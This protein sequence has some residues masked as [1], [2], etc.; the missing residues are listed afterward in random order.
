LADTTTGS[1]R[2]VP[3]QPS[4]AG[5]SPLLA[6][7]VRPT[8]AHWQFALVALAAVV[9]RVVVVLGYPP[10]FWFSDSYNYLYDAV[11]HTPDE[12]RS[13]GY[14][15]FLDL[16]LPLHSDYAIGLVQAAM[17]VAIGVAIYAVL[18]HR[19]LPWWGATLPTLPVLF[20]AYELHLEHMI[21]AD[22]L[23]IFLVTIAVVMLCWS[24]RPS[25]WT[26]AVA[27][28]LIGYATL[29]RSVGE[30]LLAVAVVGML[31]RRVGWRR[32]LTLAVTGIVPIGAYM[33]WF[34]GTYG[35][36]ALT[37]SQGGF[38]Y[39]RVSSFAQCSKMNVPALE[40]YLCDPTKL[41]DRP[42]AG[43]Y[44]WADHEMLPLSDDSHRDYYTPLY[45][46]YGSDTS[47]RFTPQ[48]NSQLQKFADS[49]I[50]SQPTAYL[51][52]VIDD[53]L[54]TFG[55]TRQPDPY[56][57][58]GNGPN[59][60]YVDTN[61]MNLQVPWYATPYQIPGNPKYEPG[62]TSQETWCDATCQNGTLQQPGDSQARVIQQAERDF[63]GGQLGFTKAVHPWSR[64]LQIY[65]RYVFLPGTVLGVIVLL[66]AV[67]VLA[68][69]RRWGGTGLL[70]WLVGALLIVLPPMTSGFSYRYVLAAAPIA[71]LAAGLAFTRQPGSR[72]VR[73]LAADLRRNLGRGGTVDQ[74]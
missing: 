43:E 74:E 33:I 62:S 68:R 29:V 39:S 48:V 73:A 17:G 66:G 71:C 72:S 13:N 63:D 59:F 23:F 32:I 51:R 47:W 24:D 65:Q 8:V 52:V 19:G 35:Q 64:L 36:Y 58:A 7:L 5:R 46:F 10:I 40:A 2:I 69:W 27:G 49:A 15:F 30:P 45:N 18:R 3:G 53:T 37:E 54:H 26:V 41:A 14:P 6:R 55:W 60:Q 70:P 11:T 57:Y 4:A 12:V 44:I 56:D 50:E 61:E 9:V 25:V 34:H 38:L 31:F 1:E 28:L 20:D 21:T 22:P 67:G 16:L 42:P